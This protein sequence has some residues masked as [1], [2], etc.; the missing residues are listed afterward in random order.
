M[1]NDEQ[2][3]APLRDAGEAASS[4]SKAGRQSAGLWDWASRIT[5]VAAIL[6]SL[7]TAYFTVIRKT[8]ALSVVI[9]FF[10]P[11]VY[12]DDDSGQLALTN[13]EQNWTFINS[14]TESV[15]VID[16]EVGVDDKSDCSSGQI[17]FYDTSPIVIKAGEIMIQSLPKL[18]ESDF[19]KH[20]TSGG[21][22]SVELLDEKWGK[23]QPGDQ[24]TVCLHFG[25]VTSGNVTDR[26]HLP[27]YTMKV[28]KGNK[29]TLGDFS[30]IV[31]TYDLKKPITIIHHFGTI[32]Y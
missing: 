6:I 25:V 9:S 18:K 8:D 2:S 20:G 30:D 4:Q 10:P 22:R 14:G 19:W 16:E 5:S 17:L 12:I 1:S 13:L 7:M 3:E 31:E 21:L 11:L 27:I 29:V 15:A 32:F 24:I 26:V 23:P 28:E